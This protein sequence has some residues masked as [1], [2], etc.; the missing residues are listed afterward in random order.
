MWYFY[1]LGKICFKCFIS[2]TPIIITLC[3]F[4]DFLKVYQTSGILA[5][6]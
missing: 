5:L 2:P 4:Y 6:R 1:Y 3:K